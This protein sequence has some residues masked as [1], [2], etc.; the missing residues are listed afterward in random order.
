MIYRMTDIYHQAGYILAI[1]DLH[2]AHL[3]D[4]PH[5]AVSCDLFDIHAHYTYHVINENL[6]KMIEL[7]DEWMNEMHVPQD[8]M[9]RHNIFGI[10]E[11]DDSLHHQ[12]M[13]GGLNDQE[14]SML[15]EESSTDLD[16]SQSLQWIK[17]YKVQKWRQDSGDRHREIQGRLSFLSSLMY[18]QCRVGMHLRNRLPKLNF[19]LLYDQNQTKKIYSNRI[20]QTIYNMIIKLFPSH[21]WLFCFSVLRAV[22]TN[23]VDA[24]MAGT[25][26]FEGNHDIDFLGLDSCLPLNGP[27]GVVRLVEFGR[28]V[29]CNL[30]TS[31]NCSGSPKVSSTRYRAHGTATKDYFK[32]V[33][34]TGSMKCS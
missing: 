13:E 7:D 22:P 5:N 3:L 30:Y 20:K 16:L 28:P 21:L 14:I 6:D 9:L 15:I 33:E 12:I 26:V 27:N 32:A 10:K 18:N 17:T 11:Y 2:L 4:N 34:P 29:S 24:Y 8:K 1:P 31:P 19:D 25:V 23:A